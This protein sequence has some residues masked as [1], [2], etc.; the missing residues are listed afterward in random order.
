M[1]QPILFLSKYCSCFGELIEAEADKI[2]S[3]IQPKDIAKESVKQGIEALKGKEGSMKDCIA[4]GASIIFSKISGYDIH[5]SNNEIKKV[6]DSGSAF[7]RINH[8]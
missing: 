8:E 4:Y 3:K 2:E 5:K 6:L 7:E 1:T